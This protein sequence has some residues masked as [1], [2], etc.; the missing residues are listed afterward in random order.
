MI[1]VQSQ[2]VERDANANT[3]TAEPEAG[4]PEE[5]L[6]TQAQGV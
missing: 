1:E 5:N 6:E 4:M 2:V 3:T